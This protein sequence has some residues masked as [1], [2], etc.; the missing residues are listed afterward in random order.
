MWWCSPPPFPPLPNV[1]QLT[2]ERE[3]PGWAV[4]LLAA[5][6]LIAEKAEAQRTCTSHQASGDGAHLRGAGLML[7][8]GCMARS[9]RKLERSGIPRDGVRT[10][11]LDSV[12][13]N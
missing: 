2:G 10:G 5:R 1:Q 3:R 13:L 11:H 12:G 8:V 9:G 4:A 6:E 7:R